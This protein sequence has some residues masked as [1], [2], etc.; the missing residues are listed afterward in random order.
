MSNVYIEDLICDGNKKLVKVTDEKKPE[1][2]ALV[3]GY[4]VKNFSSGFDKYG[5]SYYYN[6]DGL[7]SDGFIV[8][9]VVEHRTTEI[10]AYNYNFEKIASAEKFSIL[11]N[12]LSNEDFSRFVRENQ[13]VSEIEEISK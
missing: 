3:N 5:Y 13:K 9:R 4:R 12:I 6:L 11:Y 8:S 1:N 10:C 7:F 2:F